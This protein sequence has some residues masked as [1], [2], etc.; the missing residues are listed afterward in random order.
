VFLNLWDTSQCSC[1]SCSFLFRI[2]SARSGVRAPR[3]RAR[4][5]WTC[6][7]G[8]RVPSVEGIFFAALVLIGV[9]PSNVEMLG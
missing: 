4:W 2:V 9:V 5:L 1:G 8:F 6:G 7:L 3:A